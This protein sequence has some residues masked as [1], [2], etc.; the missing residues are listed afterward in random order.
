MERKMDQKRRPGDYEGPEKAKIVRGPE[1]FGADLSAYAGEWTW[2]EEADCWCLENV[3]YCKQPCAP[4]LQN[5]NLFVPAPYLSADGTVQGDAACG[6]FRAGD[7]PIVLQSAVMG[8]SQA[9]AASWR[10][11]SD[12]PD[13]RMMA[14]MLREGMIFVTVGVRGR[15][16]RDA[17]GRYIGKAPAYLVDAKAAIRFLRHNHNLLPGDVDRMFFVGVSAG[18]NL[19][20]LVGTTIDSPRF[21]PYLRG[22]GAF[23]D[24]TDSV[25]AV[26]PFCPITDLE[27]ADM[28]YEWMFPRSAGAPKDTPAPGGTGG[29][30]GGPGP[31]K[32]M[33]A[34]GGMSEPSGSPGPAK[35]MPAPGGMSE[36]SGGPGAVDKAPEEDSVQEE[37]TEAFRRACA[38]A[39]SHAYVS[40]I[41]S[42]SLHDPEDGHPLNLTGEREGSFAQYL[43]EK[44]EDSATKYLTRIGTDPSIPAGSVPDYLSGNY[45]EM[46][47]GPGG[48][49]EVS[50]IDKRGWLS[51]DGSRAHISSTW[52]MEGEYLQPFKN[53]PSFDGLDM[54]YFENEEFG[55]ENE[56]RVHFN[57]SFL[58]VLEALKEDFPGVYEKYA[59]LY[60]EAAQ[61]ALI[62]DQIDLLN[63]LHFI[64]DESGDTICGHFRIRVGSMDPH[65]SFSTAALLALSLQEK[66]ADVDYEFTWEMNH[67]L[68]D[69]PAAVTRWVRSLC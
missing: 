14:Q 48:P 22:I 58:Q 28:A 60:R 35:G 65:T 7:A 62:R 41:N 12:M 33:P 57:I 15:Q 64:R 25:K 45:T 47:R 2:I 38:P 63:P 11:H 36:P 50:G 13:Q 18:G 26:A 49:K 10:P 52:D 16:T 3:V 20:A 53:C 32:G 29:S 46:R 42:L 39:L 34:P 37:T 69:D 30:S 1:K 61:S 6:S 27:H 54:E 40:Y 67:G 5:L 55:G 44:L 43:R 23:M 19:A 8:Y 9:P 17:D 68:C 59:P 4:E 56:E 66:G 21:D 31:A 51:W 24:E